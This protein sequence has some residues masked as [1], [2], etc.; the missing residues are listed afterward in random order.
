MKRILVLLML[1]ST[2]PTYAFD[3]WD[4]FD[5]G[6]AATSFALKVMDWRQT[7]QIASDPVHY[8]EMNP[9]LGDHPSK[10]RVDLYFAAST[11]AEIGIAHILPSD[12]RKAWLLS[13]IALSGVMVM[14]NNSIG[15][16]IGW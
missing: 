8:R 10:E 4:N 13:W 15:L 5:K 9:L 16:S 12:W 2:T 3:K 14:H 11:I 7:R 6:L 1:L